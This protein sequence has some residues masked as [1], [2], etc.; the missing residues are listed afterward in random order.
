MA[1][2]HCRHSSRRY[3]FDLFFEAASFLLL[4]YTLLKGGNCQRLLLS[5]VGT[6]LT[7]LPSD[8][9]SSYSYN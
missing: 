7:I 4:H 3:P 9:D 5:R 6:L 8:T 2:V 1:K